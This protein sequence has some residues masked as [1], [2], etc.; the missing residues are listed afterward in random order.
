MLSQLGLLLY[1]LQQEVLIPQVFVE[2]ICFVEKENILSTIS[3]AI[4]VK[5]DFVPNLIVV[6][7]CSSS[8]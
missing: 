6:N 3:V 8:L 7:N 2:E 1:P 4:T 5:S